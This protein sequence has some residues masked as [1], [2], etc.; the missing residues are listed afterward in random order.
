MEER[1]DPRVGEGRRGVWYLEGRGESW[2]EVWWARVV[3]E[4]RGFAMGLVK[5]SDGLD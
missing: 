1:F 4:A 2:E 3:G 5:V